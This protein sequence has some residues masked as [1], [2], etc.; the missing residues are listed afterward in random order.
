MRLTMTDVPIAW[1]WLAGTAP[2][3]F[4]TMK[5]IVPEGG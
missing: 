4:A 1:R 5:R 2:G 3:L